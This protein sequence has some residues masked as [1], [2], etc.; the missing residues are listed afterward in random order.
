[1]L[2][3]AAAIAACLFVFTASA[4]ADEPLTL[5]GAMARVVASHPELRSFGPLRALR[6]AE[7]DEATLP[8]QLMAGASVENAL[9]SGEARLLTGME[10]TLTLASVLEREAKP[11]AR[12]GLARERL[13]ALDGR[14]SVARLDLLAETA[15]RYLDLV[16]ARSLQD[17][18]TRDIAQRLRAVQAT[19]LR[20][21]AGAA[22]ESELLAAE[23]AHARA[24]LASARVERQHATARLRLAALWG[25]HA[26]T[27]TTAAGDMLA[28]PEI[29]DL[30]SLGELIARAPDLA[31]FA[32]ETRI[33]EARLQ[34][35][36]TAEAPD[37][38]WQVGVR[39][40][41][42]SEDFALVGSVSMPL[43]TRRYAAP[44]VE[45]ARAELS[46]LGMERESREVTLRS[47]L[48]EAHGRYAGA[49]AEALALR[50]EVSLVLGRAERA[51]E[52]AYRAGAASY[53]AW[54]QLQAEQLQVSRQQLDLAL[55]AQRALIEI[56]R[57]TGQA[58][59]LT[60][61][62]PATPPQNHGAPR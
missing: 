25:D 28:L 39:R 54:A 11:A 9:G 40:L 5:D 3:R 57:L 34:L 2:I 47:T 59:V 10:L 62:Q 22:P 17:V 20:V 44:G 16:H 50:K 24:R 32:D 26:P 12:V 18:A 23:A 52:R 58:F 19:R 55:D 6:E 45:A 61:P 48:V 60:A 29:P 31:T 4:R 14:E 7:R 46:A 30:A 56:Q 36:R 13:E 15:R 8:P 51:A 21:Q 41:E 42:A 27:F 33:R 53:L 49:R 37:V 1:M 43:G 38:S 35:A